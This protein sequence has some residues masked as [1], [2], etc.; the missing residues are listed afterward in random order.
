M[1]DFDSSLV[2]S[3]WIPVLQPLS[4]KIESILS[5][6]GFSEVVPSPQ[7]IFRVF[8]F[9]LV[10]VRC[11]IFGQDPYPTLGHAN[12]LAFSTEPSVSPLPKSLQ[13]IFKELS[14]DLGVVA[15]ESGDLLPWS[16][17]GVMLLN[18]SLTTEIGVANGHSNIGWQEITEKVAA[19]LGRRDVVAN[20]WGRQ[21]QELS[22]HFKMKIESAHP[23]PLSSY[24]G[25]FGSR[26]FSR[27]NQ[28][29]ESCGRE[30]IDWNLKR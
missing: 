6:I 11:V 23:S 24:R 7:Q 26:P 8:T 18:R 27:T 22:H 12:G 2:H 30:P 4:Q 20:L 25:F 9:P 14:S 15:P 28:M 16:K 29:L 19:E 13:N 17:N 5:R 1:K 3:S 21:A 10:D